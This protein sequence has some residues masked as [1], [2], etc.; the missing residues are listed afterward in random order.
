V[1]DYLDSLPQTKKERLINFATN[2]GRKGLSQKRKK[3]ISFKQKLQDECQKRD[4]K[5]SLWKEQ[6]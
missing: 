1:V 4:R 2:L 3:I 6:N 5:R